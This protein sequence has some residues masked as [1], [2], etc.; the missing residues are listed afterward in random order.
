MVQTTHRVCGHKHKLKLKYTKGRTTGFTMSVRRLAEPPKPSF[1]LLSEVSQSH[2][3]MCNAC[4][5]PCIH[6]Q[7]HSRGIWGAGERARMDYYQNGSEHTSHHKTTT[8]FKVSISNNNKSSR[9]HTGLQTLSRA[10]EQQWRAVS[11]RKHLKVMRTWANM[12]TC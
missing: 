3:F 12:H 5:P 1:L 8:V 2:P 10:E 7:R 11:H 4:K 6:T 9:S